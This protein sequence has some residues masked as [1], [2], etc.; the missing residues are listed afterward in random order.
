MPHHKP[1]ICI[2]HATKGSYSRGAFCLII[3]NGT[4]QTGL[5]FTVLTTTCGLAYSRLA[6]LEVRIRRGVG[7]SSLAF[8]VR[9]LPGALACH[10]AVIACRKLSLANPPM[11][12]LGEQT[13]IIHVCFRFNNM[14]AYEESG[15]VASLSLTDRRRPKS[16]QEEHRKRDL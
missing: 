6:S 12:Q 4:R 8:P 7:L 9:Y 3:W 1:P 5:S 10:H 2:I 16:Q 15:F 14:S 11:D 13:G